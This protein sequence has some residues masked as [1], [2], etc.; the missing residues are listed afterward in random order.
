VHA[1]WQNVNEETARAEHEVFE[2]RQ[3][4]RRPHREYSSVV[5]DALTAFTKI[6]DRLD[7]DRSR[8]MRE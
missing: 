1:S 3:A 7:A 6:A 5:G 8:R 2:A 4:G